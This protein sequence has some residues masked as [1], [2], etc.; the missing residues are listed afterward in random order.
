M[1]LLFVVS[2][3][4]AHCPDTGQQN[5]IFKRDAKVNNRD[6]VARTL[7]VVGVWQSM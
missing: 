6:I 2:G 3:Y 4:W 1:T 5:A 7:C